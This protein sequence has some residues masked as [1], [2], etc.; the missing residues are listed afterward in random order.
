MKE[1]NKRYAIHIGADLLPESSYGERK[2]YGAAAP[3][4]YF[5]KTFCDDAHFDVNVS[6][7]STKATSGKLKHKLRKWQGKL[8]DKDLLMI[9]FCGHSFRIPKL[10]ND[11]KDENEYSQK[12]WGMYDRVFFYFELWQLLQNFDAGVQIIILADTCYAGFGEPVNKEENI[13][14]Q[15]SSF[16]CLPK[17]MKLHLNKYMKILQTSGRPML[18]NVQPSVIIMSASGEGEKA[19]EYNGRTQFS[20]ALKRAFDKNNEANLPEM[21][22]EICWQLFHIAIEK[23]KLDAGGSGASISELTEALPDARWRFGPRWHYHQG[24]KY[25][26]LTRKK[27]LFINHF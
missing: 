4:A 3:V 5:N 21:F 6:Y 11:C 7:T 27:N 12:G 2:Y 23:A 15:Y 22:E 9:T 10:G 20:H 13:Q 26:G 18:F 25:T 1:T 14:K 24:Q 16:Y 8:T 19:A 17:F